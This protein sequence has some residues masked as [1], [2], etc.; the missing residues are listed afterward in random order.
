M[1]I[2]LL[3]LPFWGIDC[4]PI[5]LAL[6]KSYLSQNN[7]S[8]KVFDINI[9]AYCLRGK[10]YHEYWEIKHGYNFSKDKEGML[11]YYIDNRALFLYYMN[12]IKKLNPKIVGCSCQNSSFIL[13]AFNI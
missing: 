10:K 6:L 9:H 2:V 7:I 4:P 3:Q 5:G 13:S 8:C 11:K 1:D 12:E